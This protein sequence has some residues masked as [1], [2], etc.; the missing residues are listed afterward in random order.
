M[1][2]NNDP[3]GTVLILF[4]AMLIIFGILG[5]RWYT[6]HV[7]ACVYQREGIEMSTWE[8]FIGCKPAER[9]INVK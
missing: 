5:G 8:F 3:G 2:D 7:Q 4:C 6:C 1:R 9:T